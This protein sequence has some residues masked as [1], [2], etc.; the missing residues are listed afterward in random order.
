MYVWST[1]KK[2]L[3]VCVCV[4]LPLSVCMCVCVLRS[5]AVHRK[6]DPRGGGSRGGLGLSAVTELRLEQIAIY[7]S[8]TYKHSPSQNRELK[9]N[10]HLYDS[11]YECGKGLYT[12]PSHPALVNLKSFS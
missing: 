5:I 3:C 10:V 1:Q 9:Q 2:S 12:L 6:I 8:V 4:C 11:M 7:G